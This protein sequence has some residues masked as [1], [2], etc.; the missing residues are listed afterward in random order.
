ML[1]AGRIVKNAPIDYAACVYLNKK[2]GE[3]ARAGETLATLYFNKAED[4]EQIK[5]LVLSAFEFS[6]NQPPKPVM[7][8]EIV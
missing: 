3:Y 7:I 1:G 2:R 5:Q 6:S 8:Y 4:I